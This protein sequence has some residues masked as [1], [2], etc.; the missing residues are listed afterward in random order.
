MQG[1]KT[2]GI[3]LTVVGIIVLLLSLGADPVGIGGSP[4]FGYYQIAGA[5][6]GA[7]VTVVGLVLTLKK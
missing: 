1:K 2:A 4:G 7:I 5:I 6:V 3:V